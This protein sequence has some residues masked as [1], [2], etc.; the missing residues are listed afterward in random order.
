MHITYFMSCESS[1]YHQ[2]FLSYTSPTLHEEFVIFSSCRVRESRITPYSTSEKSFWYH[3]L[4]CRVRDILPMKSS[5]NLDH[6]SFHERCTLTNAMRHLNITN[7]ITSWWDLV[8][9]EL[10][11]CSPWRVRHIYFTHQ[12]VSDESFWY[13]QLLWRVREI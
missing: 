7:L 4:S 13:H 9:A 8:Y 10:V 1:K 5:W 12:S 3:Q 6:A 2:L 11:R